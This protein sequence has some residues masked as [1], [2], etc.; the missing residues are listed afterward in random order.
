MRLDETEECDCFYSFMKSI[1][2]GSSSYSE[3]FPKMG[4]YTSK[5]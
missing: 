2:G 5:I 1:K 3:T 4:K